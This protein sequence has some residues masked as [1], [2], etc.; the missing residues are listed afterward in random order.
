[1]QEQV[2]HQKL[3]ETQ[4]GRRTANWE[5]GDSVMEPHVLVVPMLESDETVF[6]LLART[7]CL[8]GSQNSKA[9]CSC[10]L[11]TDE[12]S[13][14]I[15]DF[16]QR[17]ATF[18]SHLH[19]PLSNP[20]ALADRATVLPF[21]VRFRDPS[22]AARA[23]AKMCGSTVAAL[24]DDLGL[25]ASAAGPGARVKACRECMAADTAAV[26][27]SYWHRT[28]QLPSVTMC[29]TH[30]VP[31]LE[32]RSIGPGKQRR[33]FLPHE[34]RWDPAKNCES[35]KSPDPSALRISKL[36]AE[37]LSSEL[38]G[39]LNRETLYFTYRHGLKS[40]GFLSPRGQLRA[41]AL[42]SSLRKHVAHIP[43]S[44][45][46]CRPE[47]QRETEILIAILRARTETFNTLPHLVLIDFLFESWAHFAATYE[48][49]STMGHSHASLGATR[50]YQAPSRQL[51][52]RSAN[53]A[54]H[55]QCTHAIKQ[56]MREHPMAFRTH[57][58]RACGGAWRW[59][60]RNDRTWL[61][62]NAPPPLPRGRRYISWVDWDKR[63][64][65]LVEL[66]DSKHKAGL[67]V[68]SVRVTPV[69]VLKAMDPLP[70][71]VQLNKMPKSAS[72][73]LE[74]VGEIKRQRNQIPILD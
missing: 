16:P 70:F 7:S 19:G 32:S 20:V 33:L 49:E 1:M 61:D 40:S 4:D 65:R 5:G 30:S 38:P 54:K 15:F 74:V 25:R 57:V 36:S 52:A 72:K 26:G 23:I 60:Y 73:L 48:W 62:A 68:P 39:G 55:A 12:H 69:T 46:L 21:Y 37:A 47:V 44:I 51:T 43:D 56:Y 34:V 66:I 13:S 14:P 8:C 58:M 64:A 45:R 3:H 9:L 67:L 28:H 53:P 59:L 50:L 18:A 27:T 6:S 17:L 35:D 29:P 22:I 42:Q 10:L 24:K 63:D 41:S 2:L 11:G 71:S 31:L